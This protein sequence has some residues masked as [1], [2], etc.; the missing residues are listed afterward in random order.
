[1]YF[2][3]DFNL[4]NVNSLIFPYM[5]S[6]VLIFNLTEHLFL[7]NDIGFDNLDRIFLTA[8]ELITVPLQ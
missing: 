7:L 2:F 3:P 6:H 4:H 1:M 8:V 5:D